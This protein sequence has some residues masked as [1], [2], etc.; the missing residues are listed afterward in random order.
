MSDHNEQLDSAVQNAIRKLSGEQRQ[1][2][3]DLLRRALIELDNAESVVRVGGA[4]GEALTGFLNEKLS[5]PLEDLSRWW[6]PRWTRPTKNR[7]ADDA[8]ETDGNPEL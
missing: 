7:M 5:R 6:R 3:A 4:G 2:L 8:H 1:T